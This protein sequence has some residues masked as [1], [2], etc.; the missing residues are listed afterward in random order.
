MRYHNITTDDMLNGEGLR[1]VLWV[2]GC[3]HRC[4]G[5]HNAITWDINSGLEYTDEVEAE[6]FFKASKPYISGLTFSGGDPLHPNN[7][8][9]VFQIAKKYK[10]LHP[11][12]NIWLYTG[13][14]Y[15]D[16]CDFAVMDYIDVLVDGRFFLKLFNQNLHW[17]GSLN[18][19][20]IDIKRTKE[21]NKIILLEE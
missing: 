12:K 3:E 1:T 19:R 21:Q 15:E 11:Y 14:S 13:Y 6:L 17:R 10:N 9:T 18:Q 4:P 7:R 8:D 20:V 5:C 2:S 16:V